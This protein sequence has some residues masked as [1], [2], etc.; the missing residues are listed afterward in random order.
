MWALVEGNPS[1]R[2]DPVYT[3]NAR[4]QGSMRLPVGMEPRTLGFQICQ[5]DGKPE[6]ASPASTATPTSTP[7]QT[8]GEEAASA[9]APSARSVPG[10]AVWY[11]LSLRNC[12]VPPNMVLTS[13][14]VQPPEETDTKGVNR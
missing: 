8:R 9:S 10:L 13:R 2:P 1:M 4:H 11:S 5:A 7:I 6:T 3:L 12:P 14:R